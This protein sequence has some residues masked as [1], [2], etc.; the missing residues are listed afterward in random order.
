MFFAK[1]Y[2]FISL[3]IYFVP[4]GLVVNV[5]IFLPIFCPDGTQDK[6]M[7]IC[8]EMVI[9]QKFYKYKLVE[10]IVKASSGKVI[11]RK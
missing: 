9:E 2:F 3:K 1:R 8:D 6:K 7:F 10:Q 11:D 5:G 4:T